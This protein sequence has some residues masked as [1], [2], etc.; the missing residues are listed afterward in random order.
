VLGAAYFIVA[1][2]RVRGMRLVGLS[3]KPRAAGAVAAPASA[4]GR[5]PP[6]CTRCTD[7]QPRREH[8]EDT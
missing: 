8:T 3:R 6:S 1:V 4:I 7:R 2:K 5:W